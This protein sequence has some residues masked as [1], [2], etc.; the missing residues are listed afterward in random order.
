MFTAKRGRVP[1]VRIILRS[2][3]PFITLLVLIT[4]GT[5]LCAQDVTIKLVNGRNGR[6]V[7]PTCVEVS[8]NNRMSAMLITDKD[9]IA[10]LNLKDDNEDHWKDCGA[11]GVI[12]TAMK[13][14]D[15]LRI[16]VDK[17]LMCQPRISDGSRHAIENISSKQVVDQGFVTPNNCGKFTASPKPGQLI[18]FIRPFN[19]WETIRDVIRE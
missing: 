9:G 4:S 11:Y 14:G 19:F 7:A 6:P 16:V 1:L 10:S 8:A 17:Y 3:L 12:N 18:I 2:I 13:Y 15:S 5:T